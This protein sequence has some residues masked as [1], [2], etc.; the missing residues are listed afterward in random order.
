[1]CLIQNTIPSSSLFDKSS[2]GY[3]MYRVI[4]LRLLRVRFDEFRIFKAR[5]ISRSR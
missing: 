4:L 5:L 2:I 3:I 1:M